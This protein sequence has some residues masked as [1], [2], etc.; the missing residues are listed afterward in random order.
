[1]TKMAAALSLILLSMGLALPIFAEASAAR[2]RPVPVDEVALKQSAPHGTPSP[3]PRNVVMYGGSTLGG[4]SWV[5]PFADCS[6]LSGLGPVTYQVE[7][8]HVDAP[9]AYD[10]ASVQTGWDGYIFIYQNSFD[11]NSPNTN[12]VVGNDDGVGGVGT[13]SIEGVALSAGVQYFL[14]TTAFQIGEEGS[15]QNTLSGPGTITLGALAGAADLAITKTGSIPTLG[16][17]SYDLLIENRGPDTATG[18]QVRDSLP[19]SVVYQ[20]DTCGGSVTMPTASSTVWQWTINELVPPAS[21]N[22]RLNVALLNP[23]CQAVS[24]TA[25]IFGDQFDPNVADNSSTVSNFEEAVADGGFEAGSPNSNWSESSTNFGTPLCTVALCGTGAGT[26]PSSGRWWAY[27]GGISAPEVGT[28]SQSVTIP[29]AASTM[30]FFFEAPICSN[31]T[32][33]VR[34]Q[35][36]GNTVW[37]ATGA[38]PQCNSIGYVQQNVDISPFADG[39]LHTLTFTS[40]ISGSPIGS[41]FFIDDISIVDAFCAFP[42]GPGNQG[43]DIAIPTLSELAMAA[44]ILLMAACAFFELR[45]RG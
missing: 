31:T 15:F 44:M 27:F 2:K 18:V 33:F 3:N 14:V 32:D 13:S 8:F 42:G 40:T 22:C 41:N 16:L 9:G 43:Y 24:N 11:P 19:S 28:L 7:P 30:A 39:G 25:T 17:F 38:H 36:D 45:R 10:I 4:P 20:S 23:G 26:G 6:G 1:M 12:C 29:F 34:A 37:E 35:I 21:A 5:R